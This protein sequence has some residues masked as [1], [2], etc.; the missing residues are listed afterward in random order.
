MT[1]AENAV[2]R[3]YDLLAWSNLAAAIALLNAGNLLLDRVAK[4]AGISIELI[5]SPGLFVAIACLGLAFLFYVRSLAKLPLAVAYPVMVGV[6]MIVVAVTNHLWG[7]QQLS[8][9]QMTGVLMLF[10][11]VVLISTGQRSS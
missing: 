2:T 3:G 4:A 7:E 5:L 8:P 10:F 11:G 1:T 9:I 6:S